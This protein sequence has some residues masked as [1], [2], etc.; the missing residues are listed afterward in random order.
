M[1]GVTPDKD[2]NITLSASSVGAVGYAA[3]QSLTPAQQAQARDNINAPAPYEAGDNI[4]ITGRVITT[5][6]FP[7]N[8][9]LLDNW[10]FGNPV[11]QRGQ[12]SYGGGEYTIDRW[13]SG[14]YIQTFTITNSGLHWD[15]TK[16]IWYTQIL[17][18]F[19]ELIGKTFTLSAIIDG[20]L[21]S[22]TGILNE[23][24]GISVQAVG[25]LMLELSNGEKGFRFVT[26]NKDTPNITIL[27]AKLELGSVQ[28]L[29][30]QE[31]GVW[32]LNE[33]PDYGEQLR[34]CQRYLIDITPG[35]KFNATFLGELGNNND[36]AFVVPIPTTMRVPPTFVGN[37]A[38]IQVAVESVP[39]YYIPTAASTLVTSASTVTILLNFTHDKVSGT[40][41]DF[42]RASDDAKF[43][44]SA[45]L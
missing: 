14:N 1:N 11:N 5:K 7:C 34:R 4:S 21:Y 37:V 31:N 16:G 27:A 12:T 33:I 2:G 19:N 32:V 13:K 24:N 18:N 43:L 3:P 8:P 35:N 6:A 41:C 39:V 25:N 40:L 30:H 15:T 10:Y 26:Y 20:V 44:L 9:N 22:G 45:E 38:Y 36:A 17:E 42:R 29:A 28:T 23:E